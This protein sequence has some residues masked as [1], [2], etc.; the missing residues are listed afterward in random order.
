MSHKYSAI[1]NSV[2]RLIHS[3]ADEFNLSN[4]VNILHFLDTLQKWQKFVKLF[5]NRIDK[6]ITLAIIMKFNP[7]INPV[8]LSE[9]LIKQGLEQSPTASDNLIKTYSRVKGK[10]KMII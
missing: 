4:R 1:K 6:I 2:N 10:L 9:F 7:I 3:V 5:R 8:R